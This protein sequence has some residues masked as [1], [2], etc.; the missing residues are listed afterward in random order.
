MLKTNIF[1]YYL[2][3]GSEKVYRHEDNSSMRVI[4]LFYLYMPHNL[5]HG[6]FCMGSWLVKVEIYGTTLWDMNFE[7]HARGIYW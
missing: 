7:K 5:C 3:K 4:Y 6:I 1:V 2:V